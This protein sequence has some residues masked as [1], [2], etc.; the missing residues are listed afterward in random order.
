M[1]TPPE[2][3]MGF[4]YIITNT[5][6]GRQYVGKKKLS[7]SRSAIKT[8]VLKNGTK[9]KKKVKKVVESDWADYYGSSEELKADV[10]KLGK[11]KFKREILMFCKKTGQLS[12]YEAKYQFQMEVLEHPD[13]FYN[14]W[15][16]ARVR[17][18]HL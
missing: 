12:Y 10:E 4:I 8:V 2:G 16:S 6:D 13:K 9:K 17:R 1:T 14:S 18:N 5:E 11:D 7:F 15:I 3:F